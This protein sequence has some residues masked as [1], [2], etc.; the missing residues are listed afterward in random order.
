MCQ[1]LI[2]AGM[3]IAG[4]VHTGVANPFAHTARAWTAPQAGYRGLH[5]SERLTRSVMKNPSGYPRTTCQYQ[6]EISYQFQH[7]IDTIQMSYWYERGKGPCQM[8]L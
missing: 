2:I 1:G 4:V 3:L 6:H 7:R 5:I 8:G